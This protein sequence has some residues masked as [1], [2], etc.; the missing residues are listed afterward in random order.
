MSAATS[1]NVRGN[2]QDDN[3]TENIGLFKRIINSITIEPFVICW[4]LPF[5]FSDGK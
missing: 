1:E 3:P 5:V 2:N 4:L